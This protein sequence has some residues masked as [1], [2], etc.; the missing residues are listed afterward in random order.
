MKASYKKFL[1]MLALL[2]GGAFIVLSVT[3]M[4]LMLPQ[5]KEAELLGKQLR[6]KRLKYEQSKAA[7]SEQAQTQLSEKV[8]ELTEELDTF[9]AKVDDLDSLWFS[10]SRI[11]SETGV[12]GF[13]GRGKENESYSLIPNCYNIGTAS[14]EVDFASSFTKFAKFIN[15]LERYNPIVF[16]NEF[17]ITRPTKEGSEP[18]SK[19]F[20]SVFVRVPAEDS[21][22]EETPGA[23]TSAIDRIF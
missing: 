2:W 1:L 18:K 9:A 6:E 8:G 19:L 14:M 21:L 16:I 12:E 7:D 10:I 5:Q 17:T 3:H 20:L 15:R 11:A 23:T 22:A 4:F 13:Q